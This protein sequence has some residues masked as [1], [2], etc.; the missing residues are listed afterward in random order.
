MTDAANTPVTE[1]RHQVELTQRIRM[2]AHAC[3]A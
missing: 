1:G 3:A 2:L